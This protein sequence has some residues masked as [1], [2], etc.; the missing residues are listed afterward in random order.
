MPQFNAYPTLASVASSDLLLVWDDSAGAVKTVDFSDVQGSISLANTTGTLPIARGGLGVSLVDPGSDKLLFWDTSAG[1]FAYLTIGTG[2]TVAGTTISSDGGD[3]GGGGA[4]DT[5]NYI[6][7]TTN[8]ALPQAQVLADLVDGLVKNTTGTGELSIATA[9]TDYVAPGLA[10]TSGLTVSMTARLLGRSSIG[11]GAIEEI[12]VSTALDLVG[13]TQGSILYRGASAWTALTP[14][15]SGQVLRSNGAAANPSWTSASSGDVVGPASALDNAIARYDTTTGK[16]LQGST[17][18][19][20]DGGAV[21]IPAGITFGV[22]VVTG[23]HTVLSTDGTVVYTGAGTH[24]ITLV[25]AASNTGRVIWIKN[26]GTGAVTIDATGLGQLVPSTGAVDTI[27]LAANEF[28][29][30]QSGN[31]KWQVFSQ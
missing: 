16:L 28:V 5:A 24:T 23:N 4:P 20:S 2:L 27:S 22:N 12:P 13:S 31:N 19:I 7:Q 18:T 17:V 6:I 14:G 3:G 21:S 30:I 8:A 1:Q 9:G 11:A 29:I 25:S 15:T 26:N 10:N